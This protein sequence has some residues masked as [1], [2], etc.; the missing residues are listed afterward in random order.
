MWVDA[1]DSIASR[2]AYERYGHQ[3][4]SVCVYQVCISNPGLV[5]W[6]PMNVCRSV[7]ATV[8]ISV[9]QTVL[10]NVSLHC[11]CCLEKN[12]LIHDWHQF[13]KK[14]INAIQGLDFDTSPVALTQAVGTLKNIS[15]SSLTSWFVLL[16]TML[17]SFHQDPTQRKAIIHAY[18]KSIST[19][20]IVMTP[21]VGVGLILG[22][23]V[24][25]AP[26]AISNQPIW[27]VLFLRPYTLKRNVVQDGGNT[28]DVEAGPAETEVEDVEKIAQPEEVVEHQFTKDTEKTGGTL[29]K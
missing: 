24:L 20:W 26:T 2:H 18:V 6:E 13:L 14:K 4:R 8:G 9:G 1:L 19:I 5:N 12:I 15:V 16:S 28:G 27:A 21:I 11:G 29:E 25:S 7:G 23:F 17:A 10:S 3:H 22:E